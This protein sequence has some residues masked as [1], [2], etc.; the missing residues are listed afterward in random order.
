MCALPIATSTTTVQKI[1]VCLYKQQLNLHVPFVVTMEPTGPTA[2]SLDESVR[3]TVERFSSY[4]NGMKAQL[5]CAAAE[6]EH[7]DQP[8][9]SQMYHSPNRVTMMQELQHINELATRLQQPTLKTELGK[10]AAL[11]Y[12]DSKQTR[13]PVPSQEQP[14]VLFPE[15]YYETVKDKIPDDIEVHSTISGPNPI[16][17]STKKKKKY[18]VRKVNN[19]QWKKVTKQKLIQHLSRVIVMNISII[20]Y[21]RIAL[22]F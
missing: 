18:A 22:P 9:T 14:K 19:I 13:L 11:Q 4:P 15:Q 21:E 5:I 17:Q 10:I 6:L 12:L 1:F 2:S 8:D 16:I 20:T 3:A 7:V